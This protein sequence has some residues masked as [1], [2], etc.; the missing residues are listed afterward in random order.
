MQI[1]AKNIFKFSNRWM[2]FKTLFKIEFLPPGTGNEKVLGII[3][4]VFCYIFFSPLQANIPSFPHI[5]CFPFSLPF[6][7]FTEAAPE[8]HKGRCS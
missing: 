7:V 2:S 4:G 3:P 5:L 1:H 6:Y 8:M